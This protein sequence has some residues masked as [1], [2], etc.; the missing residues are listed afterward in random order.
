MIVITST[1][2]HSDALQLGSQGKWLIQLYRRLA[3]SNRFGTCQLIL[4]HFSGERE[5][6]A[7]FS[8]TGLS[9]KGQ[10]PS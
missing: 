1:V 9:A 4:A 2:E 3:C 5:N 7:S 6:S 10:T 8:F